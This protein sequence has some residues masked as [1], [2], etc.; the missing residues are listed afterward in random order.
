MN[1]FSNSFENHLDLGSLWTSSKSWNSNDEN[2]KCNNN[3]NIEDIKEEIE[4]I[5]NH[6]EEMK[7][8]KKGFK[9]W[10]IK[11]FS[12]PLISF[13]TSFSKINTEWFI[14]FKNI[15]HDRIFF[16]FI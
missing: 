14:S 4:Y 13:F 5:G 9:N 16:L 3:V 7:E 6:L 8:K 15:C 2:D 10:S 11:V 12:I 1:L